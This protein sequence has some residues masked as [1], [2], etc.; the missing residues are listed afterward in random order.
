MRLLLVTLG[1]ERRCVRSQ[2]K[3]MFSH[4]VVGGTEIKNI[5]F[6]FNVQPQRY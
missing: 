1:P 2:E 5:N 6:I 4:G 3:P